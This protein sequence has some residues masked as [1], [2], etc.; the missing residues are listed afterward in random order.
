MKLTAL[1][2]RARAGRRILAASQPVNTVSV[3]RTQVL[4]SVP[5]PSEANVCARQG[6]LGAGAILQFVKTASMVC[7]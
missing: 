6:G 5:D 4:R 7:V 1:K 2:T 3:R